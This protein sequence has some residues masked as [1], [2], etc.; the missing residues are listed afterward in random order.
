MNKNIS[1]STLMRALLVTAC[2][3]TAT[4]LT[5][6][7]SKPA[8]S[9]KTQSKEIAITFDEL[10]V[11]DPFGETDR[12]AITY[13]L[14]EGLKLHGVKAAGFVVGQY[15][16]NNFDLLGQWLN[17]GHTIGSMTLSNQDYNEI[18]ITR[19]VQEI[20]MGMETIEPMLEGFGQKKRYFRFP[21]M[22][23]GPTPKA[24]EQAEGFLES[25]K[26]TIAH[27]TIIPEDYL[28]NFSMQKLGKQPDSQA[29]NQ[30]MNEYLNHV[31]DEVERAELMARKLTGQS[32]KQILLLR[33]NR[34]NAVFI[35][36]LLAVLA[37]QEYRFISLD[38]ALKD[39]VY[40]M[41][42]AYF[43]TRGVGFLDRLVSSDPDFL[44]AE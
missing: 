20:K 9:N 12:Q 23:Y 30:L 21:F 2:L 41:P 33:A 37:E 10:P 22:H 14:L 43:G 35:N 44:P 15:I 28:Y 32:V 31:L 40:N 39:R 27:A 11:A 7:T 24:K 42:E 17:E 13:L 6:Q 16:E 38:A 34:L 18:D 1:Q 3:F 26:A 25:K 19:F 4:L 29:L 8:K 36:D 5:A